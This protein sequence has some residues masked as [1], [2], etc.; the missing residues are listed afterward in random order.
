MNRVAIAFSTKDRVE[1]SKQSIE[2]LL[3]PDKFDLFCVDG[4]KTAAGE[5]FIRGRGKQTF[6]NVG[7]GADAAIVFSLSQMLANDYD[8]VGLVENDVLL[9][10]DWFDATMAL[11]RFGRS[12]GLD[13]GAVSARSYEDRILIQR[14]NYAVMHNLG[15]GMV[16]FSRK[17]AELVLANFRTGFTTENRRTWMQA[18]GLDVARWSLF[19][20]Q[21]HVTCADWQFERILAQHGMVALALTPAKC[22]MIGQDPPLAEQGLTLTTGPVESLRNDKAF[23]LL[24]EQ[25]AA[26]RNGDVQMPDSRFMTTDDGNTTIFPHQIGMLGGRFEGYWSLKWA[27]GFGPFVYKAGANQTQQYDRVALV[28]QPSV[29]IPITGPC[30]LL[31]SGGANGGKVSIRDEMSGFEITTDVAPEG[32]QG[33]VMPMSVPGANYR[34]VQLT[35]HTPGVTFYGV[36]VREPQVIHPHFRFDHSVLPS[37]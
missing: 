30:Q 19:V 33:Q 15:A 12:E 8:Y 24:V 3:Q 2:P 28:T 32:P 5:N 4:S 23:G 35:A 22:Q 27:Q 20:Q 37:P 17:T 13:V 7:G 16:I 31:V 11:F 14:D 26:V 18:A 25:M 6:M 10:P 1:L 34:T 21:P 36:M 9:D 29:S